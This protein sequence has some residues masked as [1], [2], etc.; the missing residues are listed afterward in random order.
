M[1]QVDELTLQ[2]PGLTREEA[3]HLAQAVGDLLAERV[4][5]DAPPRHLGRLYLRLPLP[6]ATPREQLAELIVDAILESVA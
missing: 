6:A 5:P 1:L 4:P 3:R 2:I